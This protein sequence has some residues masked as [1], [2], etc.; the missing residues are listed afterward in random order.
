M[1][2]RSFLSAF[3]P[4]AGTV[5]LLGATDTAF[6]QVRPRRRRRIIRR[7]IRVRRRIRRRVAVRTVFGRPFWVVPVGLVVGWE[8]AHAGRVVV[9]KEIKVV[10]KD[11]NKIEVATVQDSNGKS[12][13]VEIT[14]EDTSD[15]RDNLEG[16]AIADSDKSTP[17]I[18]SETEVEEEV[19]E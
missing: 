12:E 13:Q 1:D 5:V 16:S 17:G 4:L 9:V 3:L 2:R 7:R 8:L 19:D 14:R 18:D 15:N 6:T 10:E 11:G